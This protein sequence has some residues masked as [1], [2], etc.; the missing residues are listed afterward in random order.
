MKSS[1]RV[2]LLL[3]AIAMLPVV[4]ASSLDVVKPEDVGFSSERLRRIHQAMQR[5][6]DAGDLSGAVTLVTRKGRIAH[7]EAH[8]LMDLEMKRPMTK[9]AIFRL[10][11][12]SKPITAVAILIL[13]EEGKIRLTDPVSRFLP[14][15]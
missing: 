6:I 9:D 1:I 12:M 14:E 11:S 2:A 3:M 10:A 13:M 7:F 15:F 4:I 5:H 8:G